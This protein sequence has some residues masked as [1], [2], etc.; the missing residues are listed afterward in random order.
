MMATEGISRASG[1]S[2]AVAAT[3]TGT[4]NRA[5]ASSHGT[6]GRSARKSSAPQQVINLEGGDFDKTAPRGTYL[7]IVV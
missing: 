2:T 1:Q 3:Q 4:A 7:N 6:G 5:A